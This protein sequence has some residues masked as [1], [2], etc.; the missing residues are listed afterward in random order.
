MRNYFTK[1]CS[2]GPQTKPF[3]DTIKPYF[4]DKGT[5]GSSIMLRE[6]DEIITDDLSVARIF[7]DYF[8]RITL[9]LGD[10]DDVNEM[11]IDEIRK[12]Y[13]ALP[14]M[15]TILRRSEHANAFHFA[16][17]TVDQVDKML[18]Q[19]DIK[20]STGYDG[21]PAKMIRM[22]SSA[23]AP[24]IARLINAMIDQCSFPDMMKCAEISPVFKKDD[25][26]SKT[27]Y[28]PVSILTSISKIF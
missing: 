18:R 20:K 22:V 28:R 13:R 7:N 17:V 23:I 9:E 25:A 19:L 4:T 8:H 15:Q 26:L 6:N 27:K 3:W 16:Y 21:L 24:E 12:K 5:H 10:G 11:I 1:N 14:N 2:G